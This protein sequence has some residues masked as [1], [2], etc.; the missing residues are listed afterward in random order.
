LIRWTNWPKSLKRWARTALAGILAMLVILCTS[1]PVAG[2][3]EIRSDGKDHVLYT[4]KGELKKMQKMY[5]DAFFEWIAPTA[6]PVCKEYGLY[7]SIC[8]AQAA[9]ESGWGEAT[10]GEFN[11]FGRKAVRG[12]KQ[13]VLQTSEFEDGEWIEVPAAFKLYDSL[14]EAIKDYCVLLTEEPAYAPSLALLGDRDAYIDSFAAVYATSP[15]Y[16]NSI[17]NTIKANGLEKYDQ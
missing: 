9:I 2:E 16:H 17:K 1:I 10:I 6:V 8:M 4:K 12:D 14:E 7:P 13:I 5:P 15:Q 3:L 11:L